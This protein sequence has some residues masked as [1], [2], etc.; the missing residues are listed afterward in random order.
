M[1]LSP[2]ASIQ[3]SVRDLIIGTFGPTFHSYS[4]FSLSHVWTTESCSRYAQRTVRPRSG[5]PRYHWLKPRQLLR[6]RDSKA[7][8]T[9]RVF[10]AQIY[11]ELEAL[12]IGRSTSMKVTITETCPSLGVKSL[13][14]TGPKGPKGA[15]DGLLGFPYQ[16]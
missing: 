5:P 4:S 8:A 16:G 15:R 14:W 6:F 9:L 13:A 11:W 7:L 1:I 3:C 10:L 2:D 12:W